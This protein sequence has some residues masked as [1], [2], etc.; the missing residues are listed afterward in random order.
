M[1]INSYKRLL[2]KVCDYI[3]GENKNEPMKNKFER[4]DFVVEN[5]LKHKTTTIFG[6]NRE[7]RRILKLVK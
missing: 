1:G 7:L 3:V 5:M 6:L 2:N 4:M